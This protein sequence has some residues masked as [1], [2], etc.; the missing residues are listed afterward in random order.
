MLYFLIGAALFFDF[1]NG[2]HDSSN[3]VATVISSRALQPRIALYT[4]AL[5]EFSAPFIFGVAVATTVGKDLIEPSAVSQEV[6]I[7]AVLSAILWDILTWLIGIPSSSSHALVGGLL[8]AAILVE[9][10]QIVQLSG[11]IKILVA[12]FVSPPLGLIAGYLLMHLILRLFQNATP[13]INV[14]FKRMQVLTS[15]GLALS[16]GTNDSQ[17]TMGIITLGLV[18]AGYQKTFQVPIWVI[19]ASAGSIALG[20]GLGGWRLISTL[21][22]KIYKI[23]PVHALTSQMASAS[24]ILG[25]ALLGGPVS[26]TQV[27]SSAIMGAGAAER[28]T[29][30]RWIV[31]RDMIYTWLFTI[32]ATGISAALLYLPVHRLLASVQ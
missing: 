4:T 13:R 12:L 15:V 24:V 31:A 28:V 16:H 11:L 1:L 10:V 32:P 8:G 2:F 3:I 21:G 23:R 19:A 7:A 29:K 9:G 17:K 26:T 6:I 22:G 5:A 25:A 14:V 20:A 30:V 18:A 27:V